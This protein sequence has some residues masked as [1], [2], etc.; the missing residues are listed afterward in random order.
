MDSEILLLP[1]PSGHWK[2]LHFSGVQYMFSYFEISQCFC[3]KVIRF[4][5]Y[6]ET[7]LRFIVSQL[8]EGLRCYSKIAE[9][10]FLKTDRILLGG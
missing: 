10:Y 5:H 1:P 4:K 6:L 7:K 2:V 8:S 9:L 3:L